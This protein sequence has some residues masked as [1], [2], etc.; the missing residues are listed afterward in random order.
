MGYF[1]Y[2]ILSSISTAIINSVTN[3]NIIFPTDSIL[4]VYLSPHFINCVSE[5]FFQ[6][7]KEEKKKS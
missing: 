3:E 6:P 1:Y 5:R 7:L 2:L 4:F